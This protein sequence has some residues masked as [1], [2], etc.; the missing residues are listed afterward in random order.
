MDD[1]EKAFGLA[2][3]EAAAGLEEEKTP[4]KIRCPI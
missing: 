1:Y 2:G 3:E 4:F